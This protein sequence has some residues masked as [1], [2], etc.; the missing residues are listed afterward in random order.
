[1]RIVGGFIGDEDGVSEKVIAH[2]LHAQDKCF[3]RI[4]IIYDL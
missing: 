1:M 3:Y 4:H 2:L